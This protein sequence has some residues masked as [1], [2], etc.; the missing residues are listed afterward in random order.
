MIIAH[1]H[2]RRS[3]LLHRQL[4]QFA[5]RCLEFVAVTAAAAATRLGLRR[6]QGRNIVGRDQGH[7]LGGLRNLLYYSPAEHGSSDDH[8]YRQNV[9]HGRTQR[10]VSL[11]VVK[12]PNIFYR[13]RLRRKNQ[14]G[15][16]LR[17]E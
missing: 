4:W 11:V 13:N 15:L 14:R 5:F 2:H 8:D 9:H 6:R 7:Y 10:A 3:N 12:S 17:K 16:L 1:D